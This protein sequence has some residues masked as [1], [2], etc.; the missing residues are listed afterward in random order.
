MEFYDTHAHSLLSFDSEENPKNYLSKS[1]NVV[2]LTEHLEMDYTYVEEDTLIPDF[3]QMFEWK[4][5]WKKEEKCLLMGVEIGYSHGNADRLKQAI[6]P[7]S[8]DLKLLSIH[9]NNDYDYMDARAKATPEEMLESFLT[10]STEALEHFPDAQI[11][12]HFDYGFR[13][14]EMSEEQ[15]EPY[16][17]RFIPIFKK[18]IKQGLAFELNSKSIFKYNNRALYEWAIPVYQNLG[19]NLFSIGSDA[20]QAEDQYMRFGELINLLDA[21]DIKT[22]A[23]FY[24]QKLSHYPI[25]ELKKRF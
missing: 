23:Q 24:K 7:Y 10:Q 8:L 5:A 15:F 14:Y 2:A 18:M 6:K 4:Q 3:D 9:H 13:I 19:G 12:C 22:V 11:F 1:T 16:K 20:H 21:F 17:E 25:E